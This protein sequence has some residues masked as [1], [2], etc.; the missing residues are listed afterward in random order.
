MLKTLPKILIYSFLIVFIFQLAS[1]LF[2]LLM[3]T[4][5]QAIDFTPQVGIDKTFKKGEP[6]TIPKSTKAIGEYV[7]AI[8]KYAIGIVG[9]LATVVLMFGG[10][11]WIVA[12]GNAER[13][14]NAK[15]W[16]GASLTGLILVLCSY[17]ILKTINPALVSFQPI[18]VKK[19]EKAPESSSSYIDCSDSNNIGKACGENKSC[20]KLGTNDYSCEDCIPGGESC[21]MQECCPGYKCDPTNQRQICISTSIYDC[22]GKIDGTECKLHGGAIKGY[23]E[24]NSCKKCKEK[25]DTCSHNTWDYEC[26]GSTSNGDCKGNIFGLCP[27]K[28]Q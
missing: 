20:Q 19:V 12:G 13:V 1:L 5:S 15:S 22:T 10:I 8:Y 4:P 7:R 18:E 14:G 17:M 6:Y 21:M 24:D 26:C 23:C 28:C 2:L 11:L 27:C 3:P 25:N 16:I 9:I